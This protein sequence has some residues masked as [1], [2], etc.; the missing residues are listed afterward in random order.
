MNKKELGKLLKEKQKRSR[1]KDYEHDFTRFAEEQIQIVTKDVARGFVPFKFNE[2]QQIITDKLE[3]QKNATGKVRAIILKARQ[4]G[5]STYCAGRVF[6]KSY[7]TPYARSVVM[8]HD[9]ATSDALFAMSKNLIRN[10][11][12]DLSPKEIRSNAK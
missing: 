8:A 5:I 3:E 11:E 12:G 2:A 4:Q 9:S 6:W 10:M 1:I 7:Y